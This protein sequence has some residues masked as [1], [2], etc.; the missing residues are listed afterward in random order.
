MTPTSRLFT[1]TAIV[2][3]CAAPAMAETLLVTNMEPSGEGSF[4]AALDLAAA[5]GE[6]STILVTLSDATL[7]TPD[8]LIY[9]SPSPL[10][11]FGNGVT[12]SSPAN[13]TLFT[14]SGASELALANMIF[15]GNGGWSIE[16]RGDLDG[17]AG[18]GIF[19]NVAA[20]ATDLVSV[21]LTNITVTGTAGHGI[22]ISDCSLADSCGAGEGGTGEGSDA[23]IEVV[24]SNLMINGVG[25]GSYDADGLRVDERGP[26]DITLRGTDLFARNVG[27][28]GV[29]LDEG[30]AGHV[31]I[32]IAYGFF[33]DNGAYCDP[34]LL[35]AFMP[36]DAE[37]D[38]AQGVMPTDAIPGPVAET[39]DDRCI[40]REVSLYDDG[41]VEEYEFSIDVDDG[42]DVD[43]AG[44]G[45]IIANISSGSMGYNFDEGFDFDE[46]GSGDIDAIFN[47]IAAEGN[48]GDAIKLSEADAGNVFV[49][50]TALEIFS[51][52]G[53]GIVAEEEDG[54]DLMMILISTATSGNDGGDL[55]VEAVQ[56]DGGVGEVFVIDSEIADGIETDGAAIDAD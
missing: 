49:T 39:P 1:T 28:D 18:K 20:D 29:E 56:E 52:A 46:H 53:V 15:R 55:G 23:S 48:A 54:G 14:A 40:E 51:N 34:Q 44:P 22:H 38:F 43:E 12:V 30:Q 26:G 9:T 19:V 6:P 13:V 50:A 42:F 4:Q 41:S 2:L 8:G 37:D 16:A 3:L 10:S 11:I 5:S 33:D 7:E 24:F 32:D 36:D 35:A 25:R 45:S 17:P 21:A 31:I 47:G 27:A